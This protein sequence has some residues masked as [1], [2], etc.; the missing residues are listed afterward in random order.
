MQRFAAT[1]RFL[2]G[3]FAGISA[4]F[5][6]WAVMTIASAGH[7]PSMFLRADGT[8]ELIETCGGLLALAGGVIAQLPGAGNE[9]LGAALVTAA[10]AIPMAAILARTRTRD[11]GLFG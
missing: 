3:L 6:V 9:L 1:Q 8:T 2:I 11:T 5:L 7:P 4:G 10:L